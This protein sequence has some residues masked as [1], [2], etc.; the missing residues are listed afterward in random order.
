M[1][2]IWRI[3]R[4]IVIRRSIIITSITIIIIKIKR[5]MCIKLRKLEIWNM[6]AHRKYNHS[7]LWIKAI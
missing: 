7:L 1:Y 6:L 3:M 2:K 4:G 5:S